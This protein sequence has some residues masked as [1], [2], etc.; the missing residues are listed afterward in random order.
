MTIGPRRHRV[1]GW[2]FE[3]IIHS[4]RLGNQSFQCIRSRCWIV[5]DVKPRSIFIIFVA[6]MVILSKMIGGFI[7]H[8]HEKGKSKIL[9]RIKFW[10][11]RSNLVSD[12]TPFR[13][14]DST[15][16][17]STANN[18]TAND[19]TA[20]DSTVNDSVDKDYILTLSDSV[21]EIKL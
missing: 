3:V 5:A 11:D 10:A 19:S 18:S 7:H 4:F 12:N 14:N 17:D 20:N 21:I 9:S 8:R 16:N 6:T 13:D 1:R 15:D 2:E